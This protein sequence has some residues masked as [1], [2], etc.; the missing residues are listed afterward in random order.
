MGS[1]IFL[2]ITSECLSK[3]TLMSNLFGYAA[4]AQAVSLSGRPGVTICP[5]IY[6]TLG[7]ESASLWCQDVWTLYILSLCPQISLVISGL[8]GLFK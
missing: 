2:L 4:Q 7:I 1:N 5:M 3:R 8:F 6:Q